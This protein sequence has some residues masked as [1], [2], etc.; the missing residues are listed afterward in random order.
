MVLIQK[1]SQVVNFLSNSRDVVF[2]DTEHFQQD[3][4]DAE[5]HQLYQDILWDAFKDFWAFPSIYDA[6]ASYNVTLNEIW[7]NNSNGLGSVGG[8]I[9]FIYEE[10][11]VRV[12]YR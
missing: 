5:A 10:P 8:K 3:T 9:I 11:K 12:I 7:S 4:W 2:W 1:I 6:S